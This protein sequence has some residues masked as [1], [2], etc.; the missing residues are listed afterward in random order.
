[1]DD[2]YS[3]L[4]SVSSTSILLCNDIDAAWF[5]LKSNILE[6]R[7]HTVPT[8]TISLHSSPKW[9]NPN[10]QHLL[11]KIYSLCSLIKSKSTPSSSLV[12]K[13]SQ[14]ESVFQAQVHLAKDKYIQALINQHHSTPSKLYRH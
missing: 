10:L 13:L 11:N 7:Y 1:M 5:Q 4:S 6:A 12:S 3:F 9:F 8:Y 14:L 2:L